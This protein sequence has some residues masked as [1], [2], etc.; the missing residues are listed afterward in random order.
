VG[1][2]VLIER[3]RS[4]RVVALNRCPTPH[5]RLRT[6]ATLP[7]VDLSSHG[8]LAESAGR[9]LPGRQLEVRVSIDNRSTVVS[10]R[11]VRAY[12]HAVTPDGIRYRVALGFDS[13]VGHS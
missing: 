6:G 10:A 2:G 7:I 12:V 4:P 1:A 9:L 13:R 3:R 5:V 11:V 8:C